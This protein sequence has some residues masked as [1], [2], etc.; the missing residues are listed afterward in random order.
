MRPARNSPT[1]ISVDAQ[2]DSFGL[3]YAG[4]ADRLGNY[5]SSALALKLGAASTM[6]GLFRYA[7]TPFGSLPDYAVFYF[8]GFSITSLSSSTVRRNPASPR[9]LNT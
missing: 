2:Y 8:Q 1:A 6:A 7:S 9:I 4:M 5:L 3:L